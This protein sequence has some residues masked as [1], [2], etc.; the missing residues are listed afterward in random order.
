MQW[1][2]DGKSAI[3]TGAGSG[4]ERAV[5]LGL[6]QKGLAVGI[7]DLD[8]SRTEATSAEIQKL[9]HR[10]LPLCA[11]VADS[12]RVSAAVAQRQPAIQAFPHCR[13]S[14][15]MDGLARRLLRGEEEVALE[16]EER[17][18]PEKPAEG[19][20]QSRDLPPLDLAQP[21]AYLRRC[22]EQLGL[23]LGEMVERTR[24]RILDHIESERF[25]LLPPARPYLEN[26]LLSYARELGV[27]E[28]SWLAAAYLERLP[29]AT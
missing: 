8:A 24:I 5:A 7:V 19:A 22:R 18:L 16:R 12:A 20:S 29:K 1:E 11:D 21:G 14:R 17:S 25:D 13:F 27:E 26:Y 15:A 9:G 6:G 3:V 2:F 23:T 10:A 28:Y 4:I